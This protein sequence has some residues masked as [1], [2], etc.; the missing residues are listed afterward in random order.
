MQSLTAYQKPDEG[1]SPK[2]ANLMK[3]AS[4]LSTEERQLLLTY[5]VQHIQLQAYQKLLADA[6]LE[7]TEE[8]AES[9]L[10]ILSF[11][12]NISQP[13]PEEAIPKSRPDGALERD[14]YIYGTP[15]KYS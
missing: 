14:H 3:E 6:Q 13:L 4:A 10:S 9:D 12:Q 2:L 5:L 1:I 11:I 8:V 15:T 7:P